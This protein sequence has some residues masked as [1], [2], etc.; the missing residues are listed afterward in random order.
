MEMQKTVTGTSKP[1]ASTS[2]PTSIEITRSPSLNNLIN[3]LY[4]FQGMFDKAADSYKSNQKVASNDSEIQVLDQEL[5]RAIKSAMPIILNFAGGFV[6]SFGDHLNAANND[7][8]LAGKILQILPAAVNNMFVKQDSIEML[9]GV[10]RKLKTVNAG[11]ELV[12]VAL[13]YSTILQK[14]G[15]SDLNAMLDT[16]KQVNG[17]PALLDAIQKIS[18]GNETSARNMKALVVTL[19]SE[20]TKLFQS[21]EFEDLNKLLEPIIAEYTGHATTAR[22]VMKILNRTPDFIIKKFIL[23]YAVMIKAPEITQATYTSYTDLVGKVGLFMINQLENK[24]AEEENRLA[25]KR[26]TTTGNDNLNEIAKQI[27]ECQELIR[28]RS[29][30]DAQNKLK[31]IH[32]LLTTTEKSLDLDSQCAKLQEHKTT[33]ELILQQIN[34]A[35]KEISDPNGYL[36]TL[37]QLPELIAKNPFLKEKLNINFTTDL[38]TS[39]TVELNKR[40]SYMSAATN[41][42]LG[43]AANAGA[44]LFNWWTKKPAEATPVE[45]IPAEQLSIQTPKS[46]ADLLT[47]LENVISRDLK[48]TG[49]AV[50]QNQEIKRSFLGAVALTSE[51]ETAITEKE[52]LMS[53]LNELDKEIQQ[54]QEKLNSYY[55]NPII[56]TLGIIFHTS[57]S[58]EYLQT[59]KILKEISTEKKGFAEEVKKIDTT[60]KIITTFKDLAKKEGELLQ[61]AKVAHVKPEVKTAVSAPKPEQTQE[62]IDALQSEEPSSNLNEPTTKPK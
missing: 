39:I 18:I 13:D 23:S 8:Q 56:R 58:K 47:E 26:L 4:K 28:K 20:L 55:S 42:L 43:A 25:L 45:T 24:I 33:L 57:K 17:I 7:T 51:L 11:S 41:A 62:S 48:A 37:Q 44:A 50:E 27:N 2:K 22:W 61:K 59:K 32:E 19:K 15:I 31:S 21:K 3:F 60:A 5:D 6:A 46:I 30:I 29:D 36:T 35:Q 14:F 1:Q 54:I 16:L 12:V 40:Q 49:T 34:N 9:R 53:L 10:A 38:E 52:N